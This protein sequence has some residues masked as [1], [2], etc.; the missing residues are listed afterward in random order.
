[1]LLDGAVVLVG[2][3]DEVNKVEDKT[4]NHQPLAAE[5]DTVAT[6]QG[7]RLVDAKT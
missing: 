1:M 4:I 7:T 6:L 5:S 2:E 3:N